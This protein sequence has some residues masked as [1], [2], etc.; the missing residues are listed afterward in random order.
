MSQNSHKVFLKKK[1]RER[2]CKKRERKGKTSF[3]GQK[4]Q[5]K[6]DRREKGADRQTEREKEEEIGGE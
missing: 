6:R 1:L 3:W 4:Q 2:K 5:K